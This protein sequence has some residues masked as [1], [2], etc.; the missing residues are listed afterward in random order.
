M[1]DKKAGVTLV[2][3][4]VCLSIASILTM[5]AASMM[6]YAN[7]TAEHYA[8]EANDREL[9]AAISGLVK[10]QLEYAGSLRISSVEDDG[11]PGETSLC[12]SKDGKIYADGKN[13]YGD[14]YY[15]ERRVNCRIIMDDKNGRIMQVEIQIRDP[16]GRVRYRCWRSLEFYNMRV[17]G[18]QI[19]YDALMMSDGAI[20][21]MNQDVYLYYMQ[22]YRE[23]GQGEIIE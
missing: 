1:R 9:G 20:D 23:E 4:L 15:G 12:F 2:E 21:S 14:S 16:Q 5:A 18:Q 8:E 6:I 10:R 17:T 3:I 19:S 7:R 22:E 11:R 13:L